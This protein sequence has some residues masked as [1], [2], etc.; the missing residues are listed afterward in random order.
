M[1]NRSFNATIGF[2]LVVL[3]LQAAPV[4][5]QSP[6]PFQLRVTG[7]CAP[8]SSI[9]VINAN[10][11]VVC[12][13]DDGGVTAVTASSP[14]TSSGGS[15]PNIA[16]PHVIIQ[17]GTTA[18]GESALA[19]NTTGDGNTASGAGALQSNTTGNNN[20]ATG[21]SAL[22]SNTT[23]GANTASGLGALFSNT[24]GLFNTASGVSALQSSTTGGGNTASG[25][26]ALFSNTTGNNNTASGL[27]ALSGNTTGGANTAS[28]L[29]ALFSNTTGSG[30][31]AIGAFTDVAADNLSNATAIGSGAV[32][33]ASNKIRLG[34]TAVTIIEGQVPFT[35]SS[36]QT[37]KENFQPVDGEEVLRKLR[38]LS[39]TSWNYTGHDPKQ[40]R[41]YGPMGQEFFAAFGHDGIGTIGSPT[42]ITSADIAGILMSA[43]QAVEKRTMELRQEAERLKEAVEAFKAENS[44]LKARLERAERT[45]AGYASVSAK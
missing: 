16:L 29:G 40:F 26:S 38:G 7:T 37:K 13:V 4:L 45:T 14:L 2:L 28:G 22:F 41:H 39:L 35:F 30:N 42:T 8:G 9:R 11:S 18:I 5:A 34:N 43:V 17:T 1:F 23:G 44:E 33:D 3:L 12:E 27:N 25:V 20:T 24:T 15:T 10:G 32:V 19:S 36:D 6:G 31:T 21:G